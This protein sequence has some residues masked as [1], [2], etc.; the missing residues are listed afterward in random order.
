MVTFGAVRPNGTYAADAL[1][2]ADELV[3]LFSKWCS[4]CREL[5]VA[6]PGI[7]IGVDCGTVIC[8]AIG[9]EGRLEYAVIGDAVNRAAK[10][11]NHT[12]V[13]GVRALTTEQTYARAVAQGYAK[14]G[15]IE[16]RRSREVAGVGKPIDVAVLA[17]M[18]P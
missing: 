2:C 5:G 15:A 9:G 17:G 14:R 12:K 7:G 8:G 18:V 3:S 4:G 10:L 11:Q 13:E 16:I 1:R 6:M